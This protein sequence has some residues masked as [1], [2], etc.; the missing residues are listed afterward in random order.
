[1]T[2][3]YLAVGCGISGT[4]IT[5]VV[6]LI[7]YHFNINVYKNL[8]VLAIPIVSSVLLN[9]SLIELYRNRKKK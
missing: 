3:I 6:L 9:V 2:Y 4:V 1:M 5:Y 7:C 8:W